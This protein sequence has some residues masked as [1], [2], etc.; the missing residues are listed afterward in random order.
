[1]MDIQQFN[2][3]KDK[4]H[5]TKS[6]FY[7]S[8]L[9]ICL[10]LIPC[11]L[12]ILYLPFAYPNAKKANI[13]IG[14]FSTG[15]GIIA[16]ILNKNKLSILEEEIDRI[17][18][19]NKKFSQYYSAKTDYELLEYFT[20][21]EPPPIPEQNEDEELIES[22]LKNINFSESNQ[23]QEMLDNPQSN[24][25]M[26]SNSLTI[27]NNNNLTFFDWN[28]FKNKDEYPNLAV[29]GKPGSGKSTLAQWLGAIFG[30]FTI[31]I[32]PHFKSGDFPTADLICGKGRNYGKDT[33]DVEPKLL[34]ELLEKDSINCIEIIKSIHLTMT[35]RYKNDNYEDPKI[36]P[37]ITLILDEWNSYTTKGLSEYVGELIREARKVN[38]RLIFL[39]HESNAKAWGFEGRI[40][41]LRKSINQIRLNT[42]ALE[43]ARIRL[44]NAKFNSANYEYWESVNKYLASSNRPCLIDESIAEVP[45]LSNWLSQPNPHQKVF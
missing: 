25:L 7:S 2:N 32:A 12:T 40:T 28:N 10:L 39:C 27:P 17:N 31:A 5:L 34:S 6:K 44:N 35:L 45:N 8:S 16:I 3:F 18:K 36:S 1:M 26:P 19:L 41:E 22:L 42:H 23:N 30:G 14:L 29:I 15:C 4:E 43:E 9:T 21:P 37:P 13:G 38:I 20:P 24:E 11:L 33:I